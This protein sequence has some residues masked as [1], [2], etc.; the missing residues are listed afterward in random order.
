[1]EKWTQDE[2]NILKENYPLMSAKKLMELLPN[3]NWHAIRN[4]VRNLKFKKDGYTEGKWTKREDKILL[5]KYP[6]LSNNEIKKL[7]PHRTIASIKI[8]A[9]KFLKLKKK[10]IWNKKETNIIKTKYPILPIKKLRELL[11]N[12][13]I[14]SIK[15]K[16]RALQLYKE[17]EFL[18]SEQE[19]II[20]TENYP[21][22]LMN[23]LK[24]LLP[25]R[26]E[27]AISTRAGKLNIHR[28]S[29]VISSSL[30]RALKG[31]NKGKKRPDLTNYNKENPKYGQDNGFFGKKHSKETRNKISTIQKRTSAF[32]RLNKDEAFQ[33]KRMKAM[34]I[35]PTKPESLLISI[36][37]KYSLP[38]DYIGD[39]KK[40]IG[41]VNPDFIHNDGRKVC[42]EVFGDYWHNRK[43]MMWH[44]TEEGRKKYL[45]KYG[46]E[47]LILWEHEFKLDNAEEIILNK[48]EGY[49]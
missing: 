21:S 49:V 10:P 24:R 43:G 11:P 38:F 28:N 15:D 9:N 25:N 6:I 17:Y 18:W 41:H 29:E 3:K 19:D 14:S 1:M 20:L 16:S 5:N 42:I 34:E 26:T 2:I 27:N 44:Q 31:K 48:M 40:M 39:G 45:S 30:S 36:I 23:K 32:H 37:N 47:T 46:Y 33:L 35:R 22:L 13:T 4:K 8:R 12:K 7:I